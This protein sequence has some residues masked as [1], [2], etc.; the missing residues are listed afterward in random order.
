MGLTTGNEIVDKMA[1]FPLDGFYIPRIWVKTITGANGKHSM[2]AAL[3]LSFV[4]DIFGLKAGW[5][6]KSLGEIIK[7]VGDNLKECTYADIESQFGLNEQESAMAFSELE[8]LGVVRRHIKNVEVNGRIVP[9]VMYIELIPE[10]L[11]ELSV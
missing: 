8:H 2:K 3:V 5:D 9:N 11:Y 6:E 4:A 7:I 1:Y 10:S